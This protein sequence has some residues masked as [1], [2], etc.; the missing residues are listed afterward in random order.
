[1]D[2]VDHRK[3]E[4]HSARRPGL[5]S[6]FPYDI[7]R[8]PVVRPHGVGHL[9]LGQQLSQDLG[10]LGRE[11]ARLQEIARD[12]TPFGIGVL[13][14]AEGV[15]GM[16]HPQ[17]YRFTT[18]VGSGGEL[19]PQDQRPA[20]RRTPSGGALWNR[21]QLDVVRRPLA[22]GLVWQCRARALERPAQFVSCRV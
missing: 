16:V 12:L 7:E 1:M 18:P 11:I 17:G 3:L 5:A 6:G 14:H 21:R 2:L 4:D 8:L 20:W 9:A 15:S 19:G 13:V 22:C 10:E